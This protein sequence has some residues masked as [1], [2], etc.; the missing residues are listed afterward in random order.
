M[1][2]K[3]F[4]DHQK[5][6]LIDSLTKLAM[7]FN[8]AKIIEPDNFEAEL[9]VYGGKAKIEK[10]IFELR[11]ALRTFQSLATDNKKSETEQMIKLRPN[12]INEQKQFYFHEINA[13][14]DNYGVRKV[15]RATGIGSSTYQRLRLKDDT[16]RLETVEKLY[17]SINENKE[18]LKQN[19]A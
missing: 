9:E 1:K 11:E 14:F 17:E 2:S 12:Y 7:K 15:L 16:M 6:S 5:V 3:S 18:I 19:I 8:N 4:S 10:M 13:M